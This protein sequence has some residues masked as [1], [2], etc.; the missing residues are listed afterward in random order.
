MYYVPLA[1]HQGETRMYKSMQRLF[2]WPQM[3]ANIFATVKICASRARERIKQRKQ[4][5]PLNPFTPEGPL[6][7]FYIVLVCPF[8]SISKGY[9]IIILITDRFNKLA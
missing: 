5:G 9:K 7:D 6:E 3:A 4:T 2:Y 1:G 8:K